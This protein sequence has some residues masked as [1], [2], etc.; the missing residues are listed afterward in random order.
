MQTPLAAASQD[1]TVASALSALIPLI[2]FGLAIY[3][4]VKMFDTKIIV[5]V[6]LAVIV[7]FA[8]ARSPLGGPAWSYLSSV[9][10]RLGIH[11]L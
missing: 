2:L 7:T 8:F 3:V 9:P 5:P 10:G 1:I 6:L 4:L 11:H